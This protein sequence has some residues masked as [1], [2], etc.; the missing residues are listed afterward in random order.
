M[1][2]KIKEYPYSIYYLCIYNYQGFHLGLVPALK[3]RYWQF[4]SE[5]TKILVSRFYRLYTLWWQW[6]SLKY[7]NQI[8]EINICILFQICYIVV[9]I[10]LY[11]SE[12]LKT[13]LRNFLVDLVKYSEN[14][15]FIEGKIDIF[16]A[17]KMGIFDL[18]LVIWHLPIPLPP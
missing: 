5:K 13:Q 1:N 11:L 16:S 14:Q 6:T 9:K 8:F 17:H 4:F 15:F 12:H 18:S 7:Q 2:L 3:S 10:Y